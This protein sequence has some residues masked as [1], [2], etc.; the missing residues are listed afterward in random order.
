[1][2]AT[3]VLAAQFAGTLDLSDTTRLGARAYQPVPIVTLPSGA[4]GRD[5]I[6]A[7]L[8]TAPAAIL[9][10]NDRRWDYS[11]NYAAALAAGNVEVSFVPQVLQTGATTIAWHDRFLRVTLSESGSYGRLS[12]AG[13]FQQ[14]GPAAPP[15]TTPGQ[16]TTPTMGSMPTKAGQPATSVATTLAPGQLSTVEFGSTN[17]LANMTLRTEPR[18]VLSLSAGYLVNGGLTFPAKDSFPEAYG[19]LAT[20]FV[21]YALS[22]HDSL[23]LSGSA[24]ETTTSGA[25]PVPV[26]QQPPPTQPPRCVEH[27]PVAQ[28]QGLLRDQSWRSMT[29]T[30]GA[31]VA[32]YIIQ[33]PT[34]EEAVIQPV[35]AA[36]VSQRLGSAGTRFWTLSAALAP[37]VDIRT[38]LVSDRVLTTATLSELVARDLTVAFSTS[39]LQSV[40]YPAVDPFPITALTGGVDA[41]VRVDRQLN[42]NVGVQEVWQN[43][44]IYGTLLTT[45]GYVS[46]TARAQRLNF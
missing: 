23:T 13:L 46:L 34:L 27:A 32:G 2:I 12:S 16:T 28:L 18:V 6:G 21:A 31:G 4:Q 20:G 43:Q 5:Y 44:P 41:Q 10:L 35:G 17:T 24:Q 3:T 30:L 42:V 15:A 8:S 26:Q 40:P 11:L 1:M 38:G 29:L 37:N 33:T 36:T 25:C 14:L 7:D 45:F 39:F 9:H 22:Q 19:P